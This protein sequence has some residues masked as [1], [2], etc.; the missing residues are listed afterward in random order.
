[1]FD[2]ASNVQLEGILLELNYPNL[3]VMSGVEHTVLLFFNDASKI[4]IVNEIIS[5]HNMIYNIF[6]SGIYHKP[7]SIF[8]SKYQEFHNINIGLFSAN[9]TRLA[10]YVLGGCTETC[11]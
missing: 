1:M 6:G 5:T 11:G 4:P 2:G 9:E 8:K 10:E 7:N 3:A